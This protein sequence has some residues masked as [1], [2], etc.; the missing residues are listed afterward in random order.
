MKRTLISNLK[1]EEISKIQGFVEKVRETKY[2]IFLVLKDISGKIQV[3]IDR[4][5]NLDCEKAVKNLSQGSVIT[6]KGVAHLSEYVKM[7]GIEFIPEIITV[8]SLAETLPINNESK[9]E[10][11]LNYRW[12][13]LRNEDRTLIFKIS[14]EVENAMR[15]FL[16][17]NNFI[18]IHTPKISA[19]CSEGGSE[20]FTIDYFGQKAYLTQSPQ[21]YKQMAM[22][23][24]FERVFEFGDCYRAEQ[25]F[26]SRH[27][28]EFFAFD[29]EMSYINS[30][31]DV[32]D[33][34]EELIKHVLLRVY[35][36]YEDVINK[37]FNTTIK[38][39][40][41][42]F[43]RIKYADAV[44]ILKEEYNYVGDCNDFDTES[45]RLI[46]K[47]ALEK[48]GSEFVF[49]TDFPFKQRA[50]YSMQ[51]NDNSG[52]CAGYDLLW[53]DQEITSGAQREHRVEQLINN[54]QQ[55]GIN[56]AGLQ[57]YIDFFKYGCPP[58]GG[59]AIGMARFIAMMLKLP[60]IKESTFIF[61]GPNKILP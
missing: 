9:I 33:L 58:H 52:N 30:V 18:E 41:V 48:F 34:E 29:L 56:P 55:K 44:N 39:P 59:F 27:A 8:E 28:T 25:S 6:V 45:E 1:P 13:D 11:R 42:A 32:M 20:V 57:N 54:I 12:I 10:E 16:L 22:S 3:S 4:S 50:F 46:C 31:S 19:Q 60:S 61:R 21:F 43:P 17:N 23:S 24:G 14:T 36:K 35:E 5:T 37:T 38:V 53:K 15:E 7:G 2:M 26:T 51:Y 49:I 40:T 47:Y